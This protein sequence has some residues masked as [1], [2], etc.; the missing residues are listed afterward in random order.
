M[1]HVEAVPYFSRASGSYALGADPALYL[2]N[3][4]QVIGGPFRVS[5]RTQIGTPAQPFHRV[6]NNMV[7][8]DD[9]TESFFSGSGMDEPN[10]TAAGAVATFQGRA[11]LP[12]QYVTQGAIGD[13]LSVPSD[14]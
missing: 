10:D 7:Y 2:Y 4:E 1:G 13:G 6:I 14:L 12:E 9:G 5:A 11:N 8:G 3:V